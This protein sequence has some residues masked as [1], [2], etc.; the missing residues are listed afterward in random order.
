MSGPPS[1]MDA[2]WILTRFTGLWPSLGFPSSLVK[3]LNLGGVCT[4]GSYGLFRYPGS[5]TC[6]TEA[7]RMKSSL[8]PFSSILRL[9]LETSL[10]TTARSLDDGL[11]VTPMLDTSLFCCAC[12]LRHSRTISSLA[13]SPILG[14]LPPA[15]LDGSSVTGRFFLFSPEGF[16]GFST[17]IFGAG[18]VCRNRRNPPLLCADFPFLQHCVVFKNAA[19]GRF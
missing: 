17:S 9:P 2:F 3:H 4:A 7:L 16:V 13:T 8:C 1:V 19:L 14:A 18:P 10:V 15:S 12:I 6:S 11:L 5:M